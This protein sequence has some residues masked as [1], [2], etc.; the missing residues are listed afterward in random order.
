MGSSQ[1]H[2][3]PGHSSDLSSNLVVWNLFQGRWMGWGMGAKKARGTYQ[4]GHPLEDVDTL[5]VIDVVCLTALRGQSGTGSGT[6]PFS[7]WGPYRCPNASCSLEQGRPCLLWEQTWV[8]PCEF[9]GRPPPRCARAIKRPLQSPHQ[10]VVNR[11]M[12]QYM[13]PTSLVQTPLISLVTMR[14]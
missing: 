6:L 10:A 4:R 9:W 14:S 3:H 8:T 1:F 11:A 5:A 7:E 13:A 12:Q 2:G